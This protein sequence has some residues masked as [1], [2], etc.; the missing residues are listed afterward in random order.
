M[1][2]ATTAAAAAAESLDPQKLRDLK[3]R[4]DNLRGYL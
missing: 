1:S 4:V 2:T 3:S